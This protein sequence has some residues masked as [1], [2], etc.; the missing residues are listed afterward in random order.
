MVV[1]TCNPSTWEAEAGGPGVLDQLSYIARPSLKKK[2]KKKEKQ[3]GTVKILG[4]RSFSA[5]S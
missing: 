4:K 5:P 2:K 3:R 1:H